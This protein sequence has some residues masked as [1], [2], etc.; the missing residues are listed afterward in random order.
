MAYSSCTSGRN[1]GPTARLTCEDVRPS[2]RLEQRGRGAEEM[3][4]DEV[5]QVDRGESLKGLA[6]P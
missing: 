5:G 3:V 4:R 2:F 6:A 1:K